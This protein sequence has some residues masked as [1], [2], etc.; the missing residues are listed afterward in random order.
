MPDN[1][2]LFTVS[3]IVRFS[4]T[5]NSWYR[6]TA[7]QQQDCDSPIMTTH[8]CA[9]LSPLLCGLSSDS[10]DRPSYIVVNVTTHPLPSLEFNL[11]AI[12]IAK[13][14][15]K[16][17]STNFR[18]QAMPL[19]SSPTIL[20]CLVLWTGRVLAFSTKQLPFSLHLPEPLTALKLNDP[21]TESPAP[22]TRF[23]EKLLQDLDKCITGTAARRLLERALRDGVAQLDSTEYDTTSRK[24]RLFG[25]VAIPTGA[26]DRSISDGDL[27]IQ[28]KIRNKKYGVFDL[29]DT[30]GD[31]DADR[32]SAAVLGVFLASTLSAIVANE[33]LPGPEI[34][35]FVVVWVLSFTPLSLVGFG[36][37]SPERLQAL[38]VLVQ[39]QVFPIFRQR[40][41]QHE[42]GHFL[43]A[44]LLGYPIQ[45]YSTNA[46]KNAVEFYPLSDPDVGAERGQKLGFD[47]RTGPTRDDDAIRSASSDEDVAFFSK[48]GKGSTWLEDRSVF[49][50]SKN[51]TENPFLKIASQNQPKD[52]WPYRGFSHAAVDRLAAVS[53]AGVCAEILAFGN[54]EG[55][56]ADISQLRQIFANA[57][58]ELSERDIENRIRYSIGFA[59]TQLRLHLGALDALAEVMDRGG[60]VPECV[61]TIESCSNLS[62]ND[63]I[64]GDYDVRRRQKVSYMCFTQRPTER[65]QRLLQVPGNSCVL[66][67]FT[68]FKTVKIGM[69]ERIF[70]GQKNADDEEDRMV[71]GMGG[72]Y[73]KEANGFIQ[74]SGDDPI[75]VALGISMLFLAWASNGGLSLH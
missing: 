4:I 8:F 63:G 26:S 53:V 22:G 40:M 5:H 50:F 13:G 21:A 1:V 36:I 23:D 42:A 6:L 51:Y 54:A 27:A 2:V 70:F 3:V 68:K 45:G 25:S 9:M 64:F 19:L 52:S 33:N 49:R 71:Q 24:K 58:P 29:I 34:F 75:Y 7:T 37:A 28:T 16:T 73:R 55:G 11:A 44:H 31:R 38:L 14:V 65:I 30:N 12:G 67:W 18:K 59:M 57:D 62:G 17:K 48:D 39:R 60:T 15:P 10:L 47:R 43:M 74:L 32:A 41:V 72:G 35:R 69:L 61:L 46:V 66:F 56:I 20:L